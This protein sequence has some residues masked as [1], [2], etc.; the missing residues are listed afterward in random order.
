MPDQNLPSISTLDP[1]LIGFNISGTQ[2]SFLNGLLRGGIGAGFEKITTANNATVY[3][4]TPPA[5]ASACI[6]SIEAAAGQVNNNTVIRF[7]EDGT[8]PTTATGIPLGAYGAYEVKNLTNLA[9][10][11]F[12]AVENLAAVIQIQYYK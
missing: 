12:I 2:V 7:R 8:D 11:K 3:S 1:S 5:D 6:L 10:F 4:L 9:N